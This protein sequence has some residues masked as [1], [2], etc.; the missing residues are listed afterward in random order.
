MREKIDPIIAF[1][2]FG[3]LAL[4]I[5]VEMLLMLQQSPH[6]QPWLSPLA[7]LASR[8]MFEHGGPYF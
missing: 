7:K 8:F 4:V 3:A 1:A 6:M 5:A 2:G